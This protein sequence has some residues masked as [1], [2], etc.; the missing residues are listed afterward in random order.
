MVTL[1]DAAAQRR[2]QRATIRK[3]VV[4]I[5]S[6]TRVIDNLKAGAFVGRT[7]SNRLEELAA[8]VRSTG[9]LWSTHTHLQQGC[10]GLVAI[11]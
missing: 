8:K 1:L 6:I 9:L 3:Y 10:S 11:G 2:D 4:R 7:P 5:S